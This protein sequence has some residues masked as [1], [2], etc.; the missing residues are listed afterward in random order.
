MFRMLVNATF[1]A[2]QSVKEILHHFELE[3]YF[4]DHQ[5]AFAR[6]NSTW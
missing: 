6:H 2:V 1:S 3:R 4:T 5:E